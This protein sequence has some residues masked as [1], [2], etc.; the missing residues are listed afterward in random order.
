MR[1]DEYL[2]GPAVERF[3]GWL[4]ESVR[5]DKAF[6]HSYKMLKPVRE[7]RCNFLWEAHERYEWNGLNFDVNQAELDCLAA[8]VRRAVKDDDRLA[9]V[10]AALGILNWGGVTAGNA[11]KLRALGAEALP[12][13]LAASRLLDPSHADTTLLQ[14]VRFMN[15]GWTKVYALMLDGLPIYDGRVGAAMGYLVQKH[16]TDE[17]LDKVPDSLHFRWGPA[18]GD[19]NRDPSSGPLRFKMLT[20]ASPR[21][22]AEC[23]VRA[24]WVLNEVCGEERFG[25]LPPDGRLRALEAALFM[26]GYELPHAFLPQRSRIARA[27]TPLMCATTATH[28]A[29]VGAEH[30]RQS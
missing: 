28:D 3:I 20:H 22:R 1:R 15:S 5:G 11:A 17:A 26:I 29:G 24:A 14:D 27:T 4:R 13:F 10:G 6:P 2:H 12:T 7:W 19:H 23:N 8:C 16:C 9:F 21:K 30:K 18:K 25:D